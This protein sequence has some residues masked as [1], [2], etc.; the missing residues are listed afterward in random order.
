MTIFASIARTTHR[1][2]TAALFVAALAAP[3][4]ASAAQYLFPSF[5]QLGAGNGVLNGY[6]IAP[7]QGATLTGT[8]VNGELIIGNTS[9]L[10]NTAVN[11]FTPEP[12]TLILIGGALIGIAVFSK[13]VRKG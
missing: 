13:R 5:G 8:T 4:P 7:N 10:S 6:I 1:W 3:R 2:F 9:S 12:D 11:G